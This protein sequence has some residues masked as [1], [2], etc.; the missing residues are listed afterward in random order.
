[1]ARCQGDSFIEASGAASTRFAAGL[2]MTSH[3]R[4][5]DRAAGIARRA[6]GR[7]AAVTIGFVMMMV[8]LGM[9]ATIVL[10]PAGIV[11]GLLGVA[12]FVGGLFR[13]R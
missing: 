7:F 9:T 13:P 12:V 2:G 8:G 5:F 10:L 4:S 11:I 3:S 6:F 1:M